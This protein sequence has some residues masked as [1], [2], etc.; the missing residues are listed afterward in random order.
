MG[1]RGMTID[2]EHPEIAPKG[3]GGVGRPKPKTVEMVIRVEG[4]DQFKK[5]AAEAQAAAWEEGLRHALTWL[6]LKQYGD[7]MAK[8]NPHKAGQ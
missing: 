4:L 1:E 6:G 5:L 8:D 3:N 2:L 7:V